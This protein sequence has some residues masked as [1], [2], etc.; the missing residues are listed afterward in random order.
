LLST[1]GFHGHGFEA[2]TLAGGDYEPE[3]LTAYGDEAL[4]IAEEI[5][6]L[7]GQAFTLCQQALAYASS[8]QFEQALAAVSR[9]LAIAESIGHVQWQVFAHYDFACIYMDLFAFQKS[10]GHFESARSLAASIGSQHWIRIVNADYAR[11]LVRAGDIEGAHAVISE[12]LAGDLPMISLG[13]RGLWLARAEHARASGDRELALRILDRLGKTAKNAGAD[14]VRAVPY[15]ALLRG[16]VLTEVGRLDA[17]AADLDAALAGARRLGI[18]PI[19]WQALAAASRRAHAAGNEDEAQQLSQR[20]LGIA[21]QIADGIGDA[22]LR[23]LYLIAP[24]IEDLRRRT[25]AGAL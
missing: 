14:G 20:A 4:R 12:Y 7:P 1:L 13:Q 16:Q 23:H 25:S 21:E 19:E 2:L 9:G 6:W 8:G 3:T 17:A 18:R 5:S 10:R 22:A 24:E 11:L 15:L